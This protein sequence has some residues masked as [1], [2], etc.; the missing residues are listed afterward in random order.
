[1]KTYFIS[2]LHLCETRRGITTSFL[3]LLA[4]L[5]PKETDALYILGD[6]F[7]FWVGDD[8]NT[9]F[10]L[11]IKNALKDAV[12]RGTDIYL[13]KG[14][15]DFLVGKRFAK[16][17]GVTLLGDE[18]V[19]DLYGVPTL[20]LHGDTLCTDDVKYQEFRQKVNQP[21]LQWV[22]NHLPLSL[23]LKIVSK[24]KG[25]AR[26]DKQDKQLDIMDVNQHAVVDAFNRQQVTH[27][28]HGHT[29]RP[30]LHTVELTNQIGERRVLGDWHSHNFVLRV[31]A[32]DHSV[33]KE[34]IVEP[35]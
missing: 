32:S 13:V 5:D 11:Q 21:W 20:I 12:D 22:F 29:H 7:E 33:I 3:E 30:D 1:M 35:K 8:Y 10:N 2:D 15:R 25:Q 28:I 23:R 16:Q 9:P 34:P 19:I 14:N 27:M 6:L 26:N 24:V 17:T 18:T 31:T 4:N